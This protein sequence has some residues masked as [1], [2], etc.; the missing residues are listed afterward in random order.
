MARLVF[1]I[2]E[3]P[4]PGFFCSYL[5]IMAKIRHYP[6]ELPRFSCEEWKIPVLEFD[7]MFQKKFDE[8][9]NKFIRDDVNQNE[10]TSIFVELYMLDK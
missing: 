8:I 2:N 3:V 9:C 6:T 10:C 7:E 5:S 1:P 4:T